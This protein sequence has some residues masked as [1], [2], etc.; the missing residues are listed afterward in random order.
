MDPSRE[1]S[2]PDPRIDETAG[3]ALASIDSLT[4]RYLAPLVDLPRIQLRQEAVAELTF[5]PSL[6]RQLHDGLGG[7]PPLSG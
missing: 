3:V 6:P 2:P 1:L 4:E 7:V 5:E